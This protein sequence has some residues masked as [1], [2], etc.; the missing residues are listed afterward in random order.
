MLLIEL[1][2]K[3]VNKHWE[4]NKFLK[5]K[6]Y[7]KD[8]FIVGIKTTIFGVGKESHC[9][10]FIKLTITNDFTHK[11][12]ILK[13]LKTLKYNI[14]IVA[15]QE[16]IEYKPSASPLQNNLITPTEVKDAL[17]AAIIKEKLDQ[18]ETIT[19]PSLDI[20]LDPKKTK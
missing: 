18:G 17:V 7:Q 4:I 12:E 16:F 19:I 20:T 10:S 15:A 9:E 14:I 8:C 1:Y 13:K 11:D 2:G 6:P 5:E 3:A